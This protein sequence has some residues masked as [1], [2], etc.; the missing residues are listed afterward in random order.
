MKPL[1]A[2]LLAWPLLLSASPPRIVTRGDDFRLSSEH[3]KARHPGC[4]SHRLRWNSQGDAAKIKLDHEVARI[5][6]FAD[7]AG[8]SGRLR[9]TLRMA[10]T[11]SKRRSV[12]IDSSDIA[13]ISCSQASRVGVAS[14]KSA[15]SRRTYW[16]MVIAANTSPAKSCGQENHPCRQRKAGC[17]ILPPQAPQSLLLSL[18]AGPPAQP[19]PKSASS[20]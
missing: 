14:A 5:L 10:M 15:T 6:Q 7:R 16:A 20:R 1:F 3:A 4:N 9:K 11:V 19:S 17:S 18:D 12:M 2:I 13:K 8:E